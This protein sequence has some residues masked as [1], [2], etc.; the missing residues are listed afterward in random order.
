MWLLVFMFILVSL[1]LMWMM[2]GYFIYIYTLTLFKGKCTP[3]LPDLWPS[4]TIIIPCYNEEGQI[5]EKIKNTLSLDYQSDKINIIV[6]DGGSTDNTLQIVENLLEDSK[7]LSLV[8][9]PLKGKI[10]QLNYVLKSIKSE[11]VINTDVDSVL[12]KEALKWIVAEFTSDPKVRVVGAYCY[13]DDTLEIEH[14]YWSTQNKGRILESDALTSSIVIAQCY[15]FKSELLVQFP[16]DVVADDIYIAFLANT[17]GFKTVY[18]KKALAFETRTPKRYAEFIPH[19][20]RKSNA[21]LRESLRFVYRLPEMSGLF[22]T[23]FLVRIS[24]Q[25]I[26]PW[27]LLSWILLSGVLL[28]LFRYDIQIFGT[29]LIFIPFL[30]TSRIFASIKLPEKTHK[31]GLIILIKGYFVITSIMLVTGITYPFFQQ[32][33]SYNRIDRNQKQ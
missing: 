9:C 2:F 20:Y 15:G 27:L 14:Y 6:V 32:N 7:Y 3:V 29:L 24:Q 30:M 8:K 25:L 11:I 13:P 5:R 28:T 21:F 10:N 33:S 17:M 18:S 1:L 16:D 22:K 19:K 4:L 31:Y 26:M 12:D 23:M